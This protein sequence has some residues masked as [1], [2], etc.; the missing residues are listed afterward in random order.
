LFPKIGRKFYLTAGACVLGV[1]VV[2]VLSV[3]RDQWSLA[4]DVPF[5]RRVWLPTSGSIEGL[6]VHVPL[7]YGIMRRERGLRIVY[8]FPPLN[9][10]QTLFFLQVNRVDHKSFERLRTQKFKACELDP[11]KCIDWFADQPRN[12]VWCT[13]VH[14][15]SSDSSIGFG[16]CRPGANPLVAIYS[17]EAARC[18]S[19]RRILSGMFK[20]QET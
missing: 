8:R 13:E 9:R 17:C 6:P 12:K 18:E 5:W 11:S 7:S 16:L 15:D 20:R 4:H 14:A 3:S 10:G 2:L 19:A 1:I